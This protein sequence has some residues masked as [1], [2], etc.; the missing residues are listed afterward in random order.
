MKGGPPKHRQVFE[1]SNRRTTQIPDTYPAFQVS[2]LTDPFL[3]ECFGDYASTE[4]RIGQL[5]ASHL[6]GS[7][8]GVCGRRNMSGALNDC[9]WTQS[10]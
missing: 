10:L 9:A 6:D 2:A 8:L 7:T 1:S 3:G 5:A 4:M